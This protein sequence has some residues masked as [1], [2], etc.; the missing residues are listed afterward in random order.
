VFS[1][2]MPAASSSGVMSGREPRKAPR[3]HRRGLIASVS[4]DGGTAFF[5]A[6]PLMPGPIWAHLHGVW[7]PGSAAHNAAERV[8]LRKHPGERRHFNPTELKL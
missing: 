7:D 1:K 8:A 3:Q 5:I 2:T 4:R 6:A